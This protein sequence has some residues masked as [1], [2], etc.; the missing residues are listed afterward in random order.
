MLVLQG[1]IDL[2]LGAKKTNKNKASVNGE[3]REAERSIV[4]ATL[5]IRVLVC[6]RSR[7]DDAKDWV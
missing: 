6:L 3:R 5:A 4:C 1:E 7:H 2:V